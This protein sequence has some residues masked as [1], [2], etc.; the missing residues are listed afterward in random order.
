MS[1]YLRNREVP[2]GNTQFRFHAGDLGFASATY[3]WLIVAHHRA[4]FKGGGTINGSGD[5]G[6]QLSAIDADLTP[7]TDADL[8][9]IRIWDKVAADVLVYD[10]KVGETDDNAYPTTAIANGSIKI[11]EGTRKK[12]DELAGLPTEFV[13]YGNY[14]K[15]VQ[16]IY[17]D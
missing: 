16:P 9:R 13:L 3:E 1:K 2:S 7:S 6:F 11:H 4:M 12:T 10:N 14:P 17:V 8:F 5:Y 15:P